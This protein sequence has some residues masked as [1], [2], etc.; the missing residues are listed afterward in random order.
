[1]NL[2]ACKVMTLFFKIWPENFKK[3]I[4]KNQED[5]IANRLPGFEI[6]LMCMPYKT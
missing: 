3:T 4:K 5:Q 6:S 2:N 1:L